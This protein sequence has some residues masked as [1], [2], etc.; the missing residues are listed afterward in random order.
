MKLKDIFKKTTNKKLNEQIDKLVDRL[1][2]ESLTPAERENYENRIITLVDIRRDMNAT[3][4]EIPT[5][6]IIQ[7]GGSLLGI[8]LVLNYEKVDIV[9]SKAFGLVKKL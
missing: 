2:D 7:A 1:D 4:R 5:A 3:K 8:W 6:H 9:T